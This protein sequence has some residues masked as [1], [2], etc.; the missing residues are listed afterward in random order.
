MGIDGSQIVALLGF[1][2]G[3]DIIWNI[4]LYLL[5]FLSLFAMFRMPDKNMVPT[6]LIGAVLACIVIAK[7]SI[8]ADY[9][10]EDPVLTKREF[11]MFVVNG[12][13]VVFPFVAAGMVRAKKK[14]VVI[15]PAIVTGILAFIYFFL[16]GLVEQRWFT[17]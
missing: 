17:G 6:L 9:I 4:L 10:G 13:I 15:G 12:M 16:F 8:M 11:G 7:I 1:G 3:T 5:F 14:G 2:S